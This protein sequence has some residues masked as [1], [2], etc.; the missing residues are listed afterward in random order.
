MPTALVLRL[1]PTERGAIPVSH[2]HLAHAAALDGLFAHLDPYL[3]R[4]LHERRRAPPPAMP[5]TASPLGGPLLRLQRQAA[6]STAGGEVPASERYRWIWPGERRAAPFME[7]EPGLTYF[8]RVTGLDD[9]VSATLRR[10]AATPGALA[11][12]RLG[13]VVFRV[14]DAT[15]DSRAD[16]E[17]GDADYEAL[18]HASDQAPPPAL[19][20]HFVTPTAIR[21]RD[22]EQPFPTPAR[23]FEQLA[24]RW[25]A[26][27]PHPLDAVPGHSARGDLPSGT[28][29][30][31]SSE[32]APSLDYAIVLSNWRGETRRVDFGEH[33]QRAVGFV[34]RFTYRVLDDSPAL[35]RE[36]A[37]LATF[38]FFAG[39]GAQ[40]THGLGQTRP[41]S[42]VTR[43]APA[44][45][46]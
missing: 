35:K 2:G 20:L 31:T 23:I 29:A 8:W 7:V 46:R 10:A 21:I 9:A 26:H 18:W 45:R 34:G 39:V 30:E 25:R 43:P 22:R 17:A 1:T 44:P 37:L 16:P 15:T 12:L 6:A 33:D 24:R 13:G 40:T 27:A 19:T 11:G 38:A 28:T 14:L 42:P 41:E 5:Y 3:A 36:V 32:S 4:T